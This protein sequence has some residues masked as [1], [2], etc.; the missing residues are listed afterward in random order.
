MDERTKEL[1][2]RLRDLKA[3]DLTV[4]NL[5]SLCEEA[6]SI[7]L[8]KF[9]EEVI[10]TFKLTL[11]WN[12]SLKETIL[13]A[14]KVGFVHES[15]YKAEM[16]NFLNANFDKLDLIVETLKAYIEGGENNG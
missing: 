15:Y 7:L 3:E 16:K 14:D 12:I 13:N 8:D 11:T 10:E 9:K 1:L 6:T 5:E 4:R 2:I